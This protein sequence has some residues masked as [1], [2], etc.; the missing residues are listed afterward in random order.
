MSF[1]NTNARRPKPG[2]A[3]DIEHLRTY[4]P[5]VDVLIT[6]GN[7]A[8]LANQANV[9]VAQDYGTIIRSLGASEVDEFLTWLAH[10]TTA[11]NTATL[12]AQ[13][14]DSISEGGYLRDFA[15][16]AAHYTELL[17]RQKQPPA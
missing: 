12:S 10:A 5:Y 11:S 6:D 3:Y 13:V 15:V 7:M 8:A 4:V 2:D 14:Y 17:K 9:R 16:F 1:R